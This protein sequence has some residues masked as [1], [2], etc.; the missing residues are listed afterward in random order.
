MRATESL[1]PR[2]GLTLR[3]RTDPTCQAHSHTRLEHGNVAR[4]MRWLV[5]LHSDRPER[6]GDMEHGLEVDADGPIEAIARAIL[7]AGDGWRVVTSPPVCL[8]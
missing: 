2:V 6:Y 7:E 1:H 3:R 5:T 4:I 8:G